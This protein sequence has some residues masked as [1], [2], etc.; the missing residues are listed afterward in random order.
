MSAAAPVKQTQA[1]CISTI[2]VFEIRAWARARLYADGE[3][4]LHEAVDEL[5]QF[6]EQSGLVERVGQDL[7]QEILAHA[8]SEAGA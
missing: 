8:F 4:T 5:Q 7:I 3:L 1:P 2:A 6:A